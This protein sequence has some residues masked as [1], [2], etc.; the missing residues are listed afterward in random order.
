M[1]DLAHPAVSGAAS[2]VEGARFCL[3]TFDP[4]LDSF[5]AVTT[6]RQWV[7]GSD[8]ANHVERFGLSFLT[9]DAIQQIGHVTAG[10]GNKILSVFTGLG[11]SEAQ[12]AAHGMDVVGFDQEVSERRWLT[13][14]RQGPT[15]D[16]V[17][18]FSTRALF[19]SFPDRVPHGDPFAPKVAQSYVE[20]GGKLI[21]VITDQTEERHSLGCTRSFFDTVSQGSNLFSLPLLAWPAIES[22][23]AARKGSA[24]LRPVLRAYRFGE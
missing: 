10:C 5:T 21:L 8:F 13:D 14:L 12:L 11:Y 9:Q 24:E 6:G 15:L 1:A 23:V 16:E 19:L 17:R 20:A 2:G 4:A 3:R 18:A 7:S 22:L